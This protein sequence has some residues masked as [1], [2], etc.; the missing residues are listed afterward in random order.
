MSTSPEG[1]EPLPAGFPV[2][3]RYEVAHGH[4][5]ELGEGPVWSA[6][7]QALYWVDITRGEVHRWGPATA[8]HRWWPTGTEVGSLSLVAG[9]LSVVV[10]TSDGFCTLDL[11]TGALREIA[12]VEADKPGNR[13][14]DGK[15]DRNGRFWAGSM[16]RSELRGDAALWVLHPDGHAERKLEG[17]VCSNGLGWSPDG[18]TMYYT[19]SKTYRIMAYD[20]DPDQAAMTNGR[21]FAEDP[22]GRWTPD[23]LTVDAEGFVWS[24][25]WDGWRVVRYAPDGRADRVVGL[26]V[27]RPTSVAFGGAHLDQLYVTTA[28]W[29]LTGTELAASPLSGC[30]LVLGPGVAGLPEPSFG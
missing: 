17:V 5:C 30:L 13:F 12:P 7:E 22:R 29:G 15:C 1:L 28:R 18:R 9:G 11:S 3:G 10:A 14:N 21:V 19:D 16:E 4:R 26:P 25:K 24:A 6:D 23:G 8:E 20:F 2:P 27:Q